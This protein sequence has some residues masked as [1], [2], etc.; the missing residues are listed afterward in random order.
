EPP[1]TAND[2]LIPAGRRDFHRTCP[3]EARMAR[4]TPPLLP[5][6]ATPPETT[7][8]PVKSPSVVSSRH[9]WCRCSS[10]ADADGPPD[11]VRVLATSAPYIGHSPGGAAARDMPTGTS[12]N[13]TAA[14]KAMRAGT[15]G[16]RTTSRV[17]LP[18]GPGRERG[19]CGPETPRDLQCWPWPGSCD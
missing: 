3:F 19:L 17:G 7:G 6:N 18:A 1:A 12:A 16:V 11:V 9:A 8:V 14:T 2:P 10:T 13:R 15:A 4:T 5:T